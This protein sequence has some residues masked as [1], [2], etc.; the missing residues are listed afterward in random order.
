MYSSVAEN[1][2]TSQTPGFFLDEDMCPGACKEVGW[3]R[4]RTKRKRNTRDHKRRLRW[5]NGHFPEVL[6]V[7][8]S[9]KRI[10]VKRARREGE[11][12]DMFDVKSEK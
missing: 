8:D 3:K 6:K 4:V 2:M 10:K 7:P 9:K 1:E 5:P 12:L 11:K